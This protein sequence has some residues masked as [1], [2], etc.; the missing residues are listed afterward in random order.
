M[1]PANKLVVGQHYEVSWLEPPDGGGCDQRVLMEVTDVFYDDARDETVV[2]CTSVE[3][4]EK[5]S[6]IADSCR[7]DPVPATNVT[8]QGANA[9]N[10]QSQAVEQ[11]LIERIEAER[12]EFHRRVAPLQKELDHVRMARLGVYLAQPLKVTVPGYSLNA[13]KAHRF[14][15]T[16]YP[17]E[18]N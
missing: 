17:T 2:K 10:I 16:K 3:T 12:A 13:Y 8:I 18:E 1:T 9:P 7:F 11:Y 5:W 14:G 4:G 6:F 15:W